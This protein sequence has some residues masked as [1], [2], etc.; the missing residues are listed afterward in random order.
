MTIYTTDLHTDT[1]FHT[2]KQS[3][4]K[5]MYKYTPEAQK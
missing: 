3:S 2:Y 1:Q 4:K 5:K